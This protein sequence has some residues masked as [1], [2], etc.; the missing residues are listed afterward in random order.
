M[1]GYP[2]FAGRSVVPV[3]Q[4]GVD[5]VSGIDVGIRGKPFVLE[6]L[7]GTNSAQLAATAITN[8]NAL[9]GTIVQ[10]TDNHNLTPADYF[11]VLD[12]ETTMF[13]LRGGFVGLMANLPY[14]IR[15]RW[16]LVSTGS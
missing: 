5:G 16:T 10:I 6:T 13:D 8:F 15:T 1:K 3:V 2:Q 7:S 4:P 12:V 11:L 9:K 14:E